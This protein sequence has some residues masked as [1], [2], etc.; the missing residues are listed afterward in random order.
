MADTTVDTTYEGATY[1]RGGRIPVFAGGRGLPRDP[2]FCGP[3]AQRT[4]SA[5]GYS[6][7]ELATSMPR[8][9]RVADR[10][11]RGLV[12][13]ESP[14][15][16]SDQS[17]THATDPGKL[18]VCTGRSGELGEAPSFVDMETFLFGDSEACLRG[19][20][21]GVVH[22]GK[23]AVYN[24][25]G[26]VISRAVRVQPTAGMGESGVA[27]DVDSGKFRVTYGG[28]M[29]CGDGK[30]TVAADTGNT[31]V[32]GALEVTGTL[33]ASGFA[34]GTDKFTVAH[35]TGDTAI[36]GTLTLGGELHGNGGIAVDTDKFT[37]AADTGNTSIGGGLD[38][39]GGLHVGGGI[40]VDT[41]KFTVADGT[42]NTAIAGD[43]AVTGIAMVDTLYANNG[44]RINSTQFM[45]ASTGDT[46][47][48]G[49]LQANSG[50]YV[51]GGGI[52]VDVN[53]FTVADGTGDTAIAGTL[54][55]TGGA[56]TLSDTLHADGGI[57]VN[58]DKFTVAD[59][60][61]D[62]AIAGGLAV[63]GGATTLSGVLNADGGINC[64]GNASVTGVISTTDTTTAAITSAGGLH[65]GGAAYVGGDI[66]SA[67]AISAT[68]EVRANQFIAL[69]DKR[70]KQNIEDLDG[71]RA[72][73]VISRLRPTTYQMKSDPKCDRCGLVAQ[74][75]QEVLPA[76]VQ[77]HPNP[78]SSGRAHP[79]GVLGVNYTDVIGYLI[80]AIHEL[81][82]RLAVAEEGAPSSSPTSP[83]ASSRPPPKLQ[84]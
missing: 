11:Y 68:T 81:S 22:P 12:R 44:L 5:T 3:Q 15:Y 28:A 63:T 25:V 32:A 52:A 29:S 54:A 76:C 39:V 58:A 51:R 80:G 59:G 45:V 79:Q 35:G 55:V 73:D 77:P 46:T 78:P 71:A 83:T 40:A 41:D 50:L 49:T 38:V 67:G 16:D 13:Y 62:T 64:A 26:E 1:L 53:K 60:T 9:Y 57:A 4:V 6:V 72:L 2:L 84:R 31:A 70:L 47:I 61:G 56:T 75:V 18:V 34:V 42:G 10:C 8:V 27:I 30:F 7:T 36:T 69:S 20:A 74:E 37:V 23:C 82:A 65:V 14:L 21:A 48:A 24:S 66:E 33:Y 19:A 43:L 17:K